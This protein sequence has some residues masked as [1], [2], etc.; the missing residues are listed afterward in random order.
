MV[1]IPVP[2]VARVRVRFPRRCRRPVSARAGTCRG[3]QSRRWSRRTVVRISARLF[4]LLGGV[5][6]RDSTVMLNTM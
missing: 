3:V 4:E 1:L 5:V 2:P 6:C